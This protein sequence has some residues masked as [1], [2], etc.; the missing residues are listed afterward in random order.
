MRNIFVVGSY[1]ETEVLDPSHPHPGIAAHALARA[2]AFLASGTDEDPTYQVPPVI[3]E[4]I[5]LS[6]YPEYEKPLKFPVI[7]VE[8][9]AEEA[10]QSSF[11]HR[12]LSPSKDEYRE[13]RL[14]FKPGA[15]IQLN[16][17][18]VG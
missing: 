11:T 12:I 7:V 16:L 2:R 6:S 10:G 17:S 18:A 5:K 15:R 8:L 9:L 13:A 14:L 1:H 4:H 3:L